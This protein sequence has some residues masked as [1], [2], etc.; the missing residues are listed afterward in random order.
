MAR[1]EYIRP[2]TA[3]SKLAVTPAAVEVHIR[4]PL[5]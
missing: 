1:P 2:R 5:G 4:C 3:T